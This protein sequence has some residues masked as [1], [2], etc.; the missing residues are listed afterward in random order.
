MK[1]INKGF[2]PGFLFGA[3]LSA[4]QAEGGF[5]L[6]GKGIS[7]PDCQKVIKNSEK[8][9]RYEWTV[10]G[11]REALESND[12]SL[13]PKRD[14]IDFCHTYKADLKL[15]S[16]MGLR[17]FRFSI[18]WTRIFPNG[19]E[20]NPNEEGLKFYDEFIDEVLQNGMEPIVTIFHYDMPVNLVMKYG[21][22][23]NRELID[24]YYHYAS[25]LLQRFHKK[26]KYWICINQINL[27]FFER[28]KSTGVFKE[29]S[30]NYEQ[31][32]FQSIHHQFVACAKVKEEA[33]RINPDLQIG[34][35]IADCLSYPFS[36]RPQDVILTEERNQMQLFYA[37]VQLRGN[38]PGF[39]IKYFQDR[40]IEIEITS[41]DEKLLRE[42]RLDFLA[43]SYYY[44]SCINADTDGMDPAKTTQNPNFQMTEWG[45]GFDTE[46]LYRNL[47]SYYDRYQVPLMVAENGIGLTEELEG[48]EIHDQARIE[49]YNGCLS[50]L[51][52]ALEHGVEVIA[53]CAWSPID[54]VSSGNG[55]MSKRYGFIY[56]DLDD[57]GQGS[58]KRFRKDSFYWYK[59]VIA[60]NGEVG[61]HK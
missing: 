19:D 46:M 10:E 35:M 59:R 17:C 12:H 58:R 56:V 3:G 5:G 4:S 20:G 9:D 55:S 32:N 23:K 2:P 8:K 50:A 11:V 28:F 52:K 36:C 61:C 15:M 40:G 18:A 1:K 47:L 51:R 37:D 48:E 34:T 29:Q 44:T 6:D 13:Y 57:S 54:I 53:Y 33:K 38:Y 31:D 24:L 27:L 42:N 26:V 21:G 16:E 45:W 14:G 60:S 22:W 7:I 39:A 43:L 30:S 25:V 41:E 49:Y